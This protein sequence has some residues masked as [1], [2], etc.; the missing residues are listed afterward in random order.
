MCD[1]F[2]AGSQRADP[3]QDRFQEGWSV[4]D[5]RPVDEATIRCADD[6]ADHGG[7]AGAAE[8]A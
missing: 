2:G 7:T 4:V 5:R 8:M 6:V 3:T 1:Y